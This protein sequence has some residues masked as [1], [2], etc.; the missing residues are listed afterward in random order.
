MSAASGAWR[1]P[2]ADAVTTR[3]AGRPAG[4]SRVWHDRVLGR[5]GGAPS[6]RRVAQVRFGAVRVLKGPMHGSFASLFAAGIYIGGGV[7]LLI[8]LII[9]VVVLLNRRGV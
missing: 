7:I 3:W 6:R 8:L 9:L 4:R 5:L 1:R 2:E